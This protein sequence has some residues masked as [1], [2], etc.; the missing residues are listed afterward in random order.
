MIRSSGPL[1]KLLPTGIHVPFPTGVL[2]LL[3]EPALARHP[4]PISHD[5]TI[6]LEAEV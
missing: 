3:V 6:I 4:M 5:G 2:M 1:S